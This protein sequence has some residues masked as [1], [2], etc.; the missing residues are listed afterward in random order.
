VTFEHSL[1]VVAPHLPP[2][3]RLLEVGA[4]SGLF[5][6]A[7]QRRGW[8][9]EGIE[10]SRWAVEEAR[11]RGL[12]VIQGGLDDAIGDLAGE[13]DVVAL[14]DVLEHLPDPKG[15]LAQLNSLLRKDGVLCLCTLDIDS[16]FPR[17]TRHRWP[18]I[19]DMHL[20]YFSRGLLERWLGE[21]G[22]EVVA[23]TP[24]RHYVSSEYLVEK[25]A[26]LLPGWLGPLAKAARAA[27]PRRFYVP[28]QLGDVKLFVC[29][30]VTD[31]VGDGTTRPPV[32]E[33]HGCRAAALSRTITAN[34]GGRSDQPAP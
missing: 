1:D 19:V 24:Y 32:G 9:V 3:G 5:M 27:A 30:K 22:F 4:Y 17:L 16:W 2:P 12:R 13:Y 29:R 26:A 20:F 8:K 18:W 7:A 11:R 28:M 33:R 31:A 23:V 15:A 25:A 6:E 34:N 14:W 21:A 10:P